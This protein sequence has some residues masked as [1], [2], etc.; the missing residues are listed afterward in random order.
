M[1]RQ[2]PGGG[3]GPLNASSNDDGVTMLRSIA[4]NLSQLVEATNATAG[5]VTGPAGA[6]DGNLPT[7][8][9]PSGHVLQDSGVAIATITDFI[10]ESREPLTANRTYYVRTDGNDS[11][12]GL[13]DSAGGA[14]LTIQ[15]AID[16]VF[17]MLDLHGFDVD[18]QVR[19]GTFGRALADSPQVGAGSITLRGNSATPAN[20]IL[21]A[22]AIGEPLGVVETR[23]FAVLFVRDFEVT[24]VTSGSGLQARNGGVIYYQ[25]IRFGACADYHIHAAS[26]S[27]IQATG[28]YTITGGARVHF[29]P[30]SLSEIRTDFGTPI[31]I[32][33]TGTPAFSIAFVQSYFGGVAALGNVTYSG[34]A[35][36]SRFLVATNSFVSTNGGINDLPGNAVGTVGSGGIYVGI[37]DQQSFIVAASD[38]NTALTTGTNKVK[39]RMPYA[40]TLTD[41]RASLSTAQTSGNIFTVD[42]NE[43]NTTILSTKLTIDNGETTSTTAATPR[44]ISDTS[45]ANDAEIEID[46]DQVGD[47]TAKGLKVSLIG[48]RSTAGI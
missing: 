30:G 25:N 23:N 9:G 24:C 34:S 1:V 26:N 37:N 5:N 39:F 43:N 33:L 32:T 16:V 40:F 8:L 3:D 42:V 36:G 48:Y 18:I 11:N 13:V 35:T 21:T 41:V 2:F 31:T 45:L 20:V 19:D 44:V 12:T 4:Q 7:F 47:G 38:E 10:T 22:T 6:T 27:Y 15:H 14:F 46:I 28:S 17:G 29:R